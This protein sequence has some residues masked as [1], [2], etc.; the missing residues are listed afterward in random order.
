VATNDVNK[1]PTFKAKTKA[2]DLTFKAKAKNLTAFTVEYFIDTGIV[3]NFNKY[4]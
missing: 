3:I 2:K 4:A 1:N